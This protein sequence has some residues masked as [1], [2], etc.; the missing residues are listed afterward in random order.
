MVESSMVEE[1]RGTSAAPLVDLKAQKTIG[2]DN[3]NA[4]KRE[5][6]P[7][8]VDAYVTRRAVSLRG[9]PRFAAT[10]KAHIGAGTSISVLGAQGDWLKVKARPSGAVGYVR[11]EY[12]VPQG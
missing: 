5:D 9:E 1:E 7:E 11:K 6:Q 10:A 12:L 2:A 8:G 3:R 4:R